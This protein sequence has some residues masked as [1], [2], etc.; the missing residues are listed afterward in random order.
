MAL[1]W[2]ARALPA[3]VAVILLGYLLAATWTVSEGEL[4]Q[5]AIEQATDGDTIDVGPGHYAEHLDFLGKDIILQSTDGPADTILD[6]SDVWD[7][8][9]VS[10]RSSEPIS[11]TLSG[12]TVTGGHGQPYLWDVGRGWMGGGV[13]IRDAGATILNCIFV[14]NN[15]RH[16]GQ[17]HGGA[18]AIIKSQAIVRNSTFR[19][20]LGFYGGGAMGVVSS[21]VLVEDNLFEGNRGTHGGAVIVLQDSSVDFQANQWIDNHGGHGGT[22]L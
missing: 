1:E 22:Y 5:D 9:V 16:S 14:D 4:I 2:G 10:F 18:V 6:G 13:F 20:N 12:F 19:D 7:T 21:Q 17:S 3:G 11:A 15:A 8:S